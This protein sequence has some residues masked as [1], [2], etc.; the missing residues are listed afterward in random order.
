MDTTCERAGSAAANKKG[1]AFTRPAGT[2]STPKVSG[3]NYFGVGLAVLEPVEGFGAAG[4]AAAPDVGAATPDCVLNISITGFVISNASP[5]SNTGP[6]GHGF[7][8]SITK[9][10]PLSCAYF[11][12]MGASLVSTLLA[13]SCC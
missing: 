6:C 11:T 8:V 13:I 10:N 7:E 2:S 5:A 4:F 12:T 9:P 3:S 1:R